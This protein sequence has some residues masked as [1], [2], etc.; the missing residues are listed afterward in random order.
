MAGPVRSRGAVA[1]I[2]ATMV[3]RYPAI[4]PV[5]ARSAHTCQI[6]VTNATAEYVITN[7]ASERAAMYLGPR[8]SARAPD[9]ALK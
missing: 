4:T 7:P 2:N 9:Q 1:T 3:G 5:A 8:R 6:S